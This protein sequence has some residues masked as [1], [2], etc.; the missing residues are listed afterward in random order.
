MARERKDL[1][2]Y[3]GSYT[4]MAQPMKNSR[5]ALSND[6]VFN[7]YRYFFEINNVLFYSTSQYSTPHYMQYDLLI[8]V[9]MH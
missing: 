9:T 6:P 2:D 1:M 7:K 4:M 5:F 8:L 3:N